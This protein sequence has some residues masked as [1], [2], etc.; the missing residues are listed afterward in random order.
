MAKNPYINIY[1]GD[2]TEGEKDGFAISSD[3]SFSAPLSVLFDVSFPD[4]VDTR[5]PIYYKVVK[6]AVRL[7]EG[8]EV[9][10]GVGISVPSYGPWRLTVYEPTLAANWENAVS[11]GGITD[12]NKIF[13]AR[14]SGSASS[15][16][17][18][19]NGHDSDLTLHAKIFPL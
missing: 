9:D 6:L 11:L 1:A 10:W 16:T 13:Y 15:P 12:V 19:G 3:G 5:Y 18:F 14:V 4:L 17:A 8:F 2:P 7:E